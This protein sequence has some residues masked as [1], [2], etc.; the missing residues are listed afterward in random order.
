[1]DMHDPIET[2]SE[3]PEDEPMPDLTSL[4]EPVVSGGESHVAPAPAG[5][6]MDTL[7]SLKTLSGAQL[8][9][10]VPPLVSD[11]RACA[12]FRQ[13]LVHIPSRLE[14]LKNQGNAM[15][16]DELILHVTACLRLSGRT[17]VEFLDPLIALG[18]SKSGS[19]DVVTDWIRQHPDMTTIIT[20]LPVH[21]HWVPIAWT[22]G[23]CE[24]QVSMWEHTDVEIESLCP[25]HGLIS[26]SWGKPRFVLACTRR[27]FSRGFCGA[28][29]VAFMFHKLLGKDLPTSEDD[30]AL[31]HQDLRLSFEAACSSAVYLPKPW[32]WGLGA[33]DVLS[34]TGELLKAHGVPSAQ[35]QLRA[36]L[37]LQA[38]GKPEV[39]Q[40]LNGISPWKSLK[41][42][43]NMQTPPLQMVLPD[44]QLQHNQGKPASKPKSKAASRKPVPSKPAD[45]DPSKLLIEHGA[46]RVGQDEP[47]GQL[48]FASLGPL[49]SGVALASFQEAQPF[50][51]SGKLLTNHGLALLIINPPGELQTQLEWST[52]RFA[53]KCSV[54]HEPML[55]AGVLVQLGRATV[56]QFTAK[57]I[58]AIPSVEVACVRVTV[59]QDQWEGQWEDF[60]ARPV[61]HVLSVLKCLQTCRLGG[62]CQCGAWHPAADQTHD[63]VLDVFR[64]QYF[65]DAGRAVKW[66]KATHFAVLIRY[67]KC[68]E[69]QVLCSSGQHGVFLEPKT[70]DALRPH[71]DFQVV[72]LP[73]LDFS[74]VVHKA[75]CEVDCLGVARSGRRFGLRVH[76]SNFQRLFTSSK[77]DAVYLAP[78]SRMTFLCGP[79]PFGSDRKNIARILKSSGWECR[80]LQPLHHVPG[81]LMWSI[82]AIAE[83]TTNVLPMQHGQV[84]ITRQDAKD[85]PAGPDMQVVG[86]AK[87]V[88]MC[89][90]A[91]PQGTD[92]WMQSDPWSKALSQ[93]PPVPC[94]PPAPHVLHE[95]EQRLEQNILA[96]LPTG[97]VEKMEVDDQ[98]QRMQYLESQV[99][100]LASRQTALESTVQDHHQQ[101]T[102]QVQSLQQQMKVQLDMQT[103]HMSTM[104]SDQMMRIEAILAKK[105][106]TE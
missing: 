87:T 78:G 92:P 2:V 7:Q 64:R 105:P 26:A 81:G 38:L 28:A 48:P 3:Q 72:W 15:G 13:A 21:D 33:P 101:S 61:R 79:W 86:H 71:S 50:L 11:G 53:A 4:P 54:N 9:S 104:L 88:D 75:K 82:Q 10:L 106:R 62:D 60:S 91:E 30:L 6:V 58:P 97:Q 37:V 90:Q 16:D 17:N 32:C 67:I 29:A 63:A 41:A 96:K 83:P 103:Q 36:K 8:A 73:H 70:E 94:A 68:L 35:V 84:L 5:I 55:V 43:A 47:L 14:I 56:Y 65:N 80:P 57:D 49:H 45:L 102:A 40:A 31:L 42:L 95:L 39:S 89:R 19:S 66:D 22:V 100:Q 18:W 12:M 74:G 1:M 46:F 69:T 20:V 59:Y 76:V 27:S 52:I 77:P 93:A 98:D 34:L 99:Q 85:A 25:L 51:T 44:E 24:V 23:L